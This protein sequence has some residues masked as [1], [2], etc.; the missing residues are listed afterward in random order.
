MTTACRCG[1]TI[2]ACGRQ[3]SARVGCRLASSSIK[4]RADSSHV[5]RNGDR[6]GIEYLERVLISYS[7]TYRRRA[8][9]LGERKDT[10]SLVLPLDAVVY[11][12]AYSLAC[13]M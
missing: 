13:Y 7:F 6:G 10:I 5:V 4:R 12:L 3:S 2:V 11:T 1:Q 9:S 8:L